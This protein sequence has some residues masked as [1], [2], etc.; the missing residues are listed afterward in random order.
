MNNLECR[1]CGT[2]LTGADHEQRD[3][4][5]DLGLLI[6]RKTIRSIDAWICPGCVTEHQVVPNLDGLVA[7]MMRRLDKHIFSWNNGWNAE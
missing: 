2:V 1:R 4:T 6:G 7:A 5:I 3:V